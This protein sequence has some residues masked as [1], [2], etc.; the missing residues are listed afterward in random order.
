MRGATHNN[1]FLI[2]QGTATTGGTLSDPSVDITLSAPH[3]DTMFPCIVLTPIGTNTHDVNVFVSDI[4]YNSS[5]GQWTVTIE[6]S[7][8][9]ITVQYRVLGYTHNNKKH[10][11]AHGNGLGGSYS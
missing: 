8:P 7:Q 10:A 5:S 2:E 4:S 11:T 1:N 9:S 6:S 3:R